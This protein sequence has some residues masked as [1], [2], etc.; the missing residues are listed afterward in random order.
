MS[1][2]YLAGKKNIWYGFVFGI[3]GAPFWFY[4]T[5]TT[6]QWGMFFTNIWFTGNH[7][8]GIINHMKEKK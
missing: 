6:G 4:A 2:F 7:I 1:I 8:R 3:C 5:Y